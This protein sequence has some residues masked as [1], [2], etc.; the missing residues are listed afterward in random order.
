MSLP[1]AAKPQAAPRRSSR[2]IR[3]RG[4]VPVRSRGAQSARHATAPDATPV[5][6]P[7]AASHSPSIL[8]RCKRANLALGFAKEHGTAPYGTCMATGSW[9]ADQRSSRGIGAR[10]G[11]LITCGE[12]IPGIWIPGLGGHYTTWR[13]SRSI[14]QRRTLSSVIRQRARRS[15]VRRVLQAQGSK[16]LGRCVTLKTSPT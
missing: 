15:I 12:T 13:G 11:G 16:S 3:W 8:I 9:T 14:A 4:D 7:L 5:A 2:S 10:R 6:S 1:G